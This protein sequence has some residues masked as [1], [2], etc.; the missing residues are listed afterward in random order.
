MRNISISFQPF[1]DDKE[2]LPRAMDFMSMEIWRPTHQLTAFVAEVNC[3]CYFSIKAA[4]AQGPPDSHAN[5]QM[6][7]RKRMA[8]DVDTFREFLV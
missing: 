8:W 4:E 5:I 1:I 3:H 7:Q 6:D 2:S